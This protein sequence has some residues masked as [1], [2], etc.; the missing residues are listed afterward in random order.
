MLERGGMEM[1]MEMALLDDDPWALG[2]FCLMP[3]DFG[4]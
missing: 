2:T 1:E 3:M 4:V